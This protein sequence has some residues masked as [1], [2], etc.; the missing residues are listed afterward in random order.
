MI[1]GA[2]LPFTRSGIIG[3][4]ILGLGRALGEKM[5]VT[6]VIGN[7]HEIA[8]S[9][10]APAYKMAALV[11]HQADVA[12]DDGEPDAD[13]DGKMGE[14]GNVGETGDVAAAASKTVTVT[15]AAGHYV[16]ICNE[17]GHYT[18]GMHMTFTV[19]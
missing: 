3:G 5:A 2:V 10:A 12:E 8:E 7:T 15:L 17:V 6:M 14:N 9:V 19:N 1:W 18:S 13:E 16:L 4:V 11:G